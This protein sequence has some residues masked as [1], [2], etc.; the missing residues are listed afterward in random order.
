[1]CGGDALDDAPSPAERQVGSRGDWGGSFRGPAGRRLSG[2]LR[3]RSKRYGYYE[4]KSCQRVRIRKAELE[5][6]FIELFDRLRP[7]EEVLRLGKPL[8]LQRFAV[9]GPWTSPSIPLPDSTTI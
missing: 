6:G 8:T 1:M 2:A 4:C 3:G 9:R 5:E 7:A